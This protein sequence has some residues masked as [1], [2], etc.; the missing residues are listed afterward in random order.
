M[1]HV[2]DKG[3][4]PSD[5]TITLERVGCFVDIWKFGWGTAY[6]EPS[7]MEKVALLEGHAVA[8]CLGGTLLEAAWMLD[9][10]DA[11]LSWAEEVGVSHV[12]VSNGV[13]GMPYE[14]KRRLIER[15]SSR[16]VVVAE[17]GSKHPDALMTPKGWAEE[18]GRDLEAGATYAITEGREYGNVGLY[19]EHGQ[20]Q[21]APAAQVVDL[22]DHEIGLARV[23]FEAPSKDQQAWFINRVGPEVNLG[24]IPPG[25][26]FALESLRM[27]LRGDTLHLLGGQARRRSSAGRR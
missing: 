12:E 11:C 1:T 23:I 22:V 24:N 10:V 13:V 9:Q 27:G 25:E 18:M 15:A 19:N 2:L 6:L 8:T 5:L 20:V 21:E 17:V 4:A 3:L 7:L 26:V 16:F 14:E